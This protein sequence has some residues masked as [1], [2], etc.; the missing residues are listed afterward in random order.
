[1]L[2]RKRASFRKKHQGQ[3]LN[4]ERKILP[5]TYSI[6]KPVF[7]QKGISSRG[8]TPLFAGDCTRTSC[9]NGKK[10]APAPLN[11]SNPEKRRY[12]RIK[13]GENS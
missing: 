9:S 10:N 3:F 7:S 1:M 4:K 8:R 13:K 12:P 5:R 6:K 2:R 11:L